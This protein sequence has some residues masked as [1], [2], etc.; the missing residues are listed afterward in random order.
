MSNKKL[1]LEE[2]IIEELEDE[3]DEII[4]LEKEKPN[5]YFTGFA[6]MKLKLIEQMNQQKKKQKLN[7]EPSIRLNE[8]K[9]KNLMN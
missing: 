7:S 1:K 2:E 4:V 3:D 9:K 6:Q 8:D 5:N